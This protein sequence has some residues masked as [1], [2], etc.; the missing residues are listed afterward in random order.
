MGTDRQSPIQRSQELS[1]QQVKFT[2]TDA[3]HFRIM[4]ICTEGVAQCLTGD[5]DCSDDETM[6][7]QGR[8]GE[9]G[10]ARADLVNIVEGE[11]EDR[12]LGS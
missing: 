11:Q 9:H 1:F 4:R 10:H 2:N 12:F 6:A 5:D 7:S 3:A 8:E